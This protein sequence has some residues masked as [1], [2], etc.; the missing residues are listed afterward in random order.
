MVAA[1]INF[2]QGTK[3]NLKPME[4]KEKHEHKG[5]N[6]PPNSSK[7][8][9]SNNKAKEKG[10][11]KGKNRL[12]PEELESYRK[13]NRCFKCGEQGHTYRACPQ[14]NASN[15]QPRASIIEAPK[16]DVHC[17]GSPLSYAWGKVREHDAFILF[18]PGSTH[19]FISHELATKL[20]IQEFE[21]GDAMKA[22]GA[23]IGQDAS[24]TP[25]IGKLRLH[26]QGYVD[27][28]DFFIYPLK[29]EDVIL[30]APWFDRLAASIKFPEGR[31]SFKFREKNMF[32]DAQESG[33]AL[34]DVPSQTA[35]AI[36]EKGSPCPSYATNSC[37]LPLPRR[38]SHPR[39]PL[40][41]PLLWETTW[42]DGYRED[43]S[44]SQDRQ[45]IP[46]VHEV[47]EGS[48]QAKE[49]FPHAACPCE[50]V[51]ENVK[52]VVTRL[53]VDAK[54]DGKDPNAYVDA[55]VDDL[56]GNASLSQGG[57]SGS[58]STHASGNAH[59]S[60]IGT[61]A[62]K[63]NVGSSSKKRKGAQGPLASAFSLQAR[64]QADQALRRF[65]YAEDIPEWK[66]RS[67]F[68]LEMVKAI[69]QVV[70]S[71]VPPTYNALCT[72]ELNDEEVICGKMKV[73][74]TSKDARNKQ[75]SA[76]DLKN[77]DFFFSKIYNVD[78]QHL[79]PVQK[80]VEKLGCEAVYNKEEWVTESSKSKDEQFKQSKSLQI[81]KHETFPKQEA[82]CTLDS[83]PLQ[84]DVGRDIERKV[85]QGSA[86][87]RQQ[88]HDTEEI[89]EKKAKTSASAILRLGEVLSRE[90]DKAEKATRF[91]EIKVRKNLKV[92]G[93]ELQSKTDLPACTPPLSEVKLQSSLQFANVDKVDEQAVQSK[94][95]FPPFD[96][97]QTKAK[98][99]NA[100]NSLPLKT[101]AASEIRSLESDDTLKRAVTNSETSRQ[102]AEIGGLS[103]GDPSSKESLSTSSAVND[104][105]GQAMTGS[106]NSRQLRE[107]DS[108]LK[109]DRSA[110]NLASLDSSKKD[111]I[112]SEI[113]NDP[114]K[115]ADHFSGSVDTE[116]NLVK[117]TISNLK[118]NIEAEEISKLIASII[119][120]SLEG[121]KDQEKVNSHPL[122][123][124]EK[125][126]KDFDSKDENHNVNT[127]FKTGTGSD[128]EMKAVTTIELVKEKR[129]IFKE[130][131]WEENLQQGLT[132]GKVLLLQNLDPSLTSADVC[133]LV[134]SW[135]EEL[136]HMGYSDRIPAV[137]PSIQGLLLIITSLEWM[138]QQQEMLKHIFQGVSAVRVI[139]Q[140]TVCPYGQ[141]LA[142]FDSR[143]LADNALQEM[144]RKCLVLASNKRPIFATKFK[145][146]CNLTKFPGHLALEKLKLSRN[147][148]ADDYKR[149]VSTSHSSQPNTIEYEM[150]IEWRRLQEITQTCQVELFE[151]QQKEIEEIRKNCVTKDF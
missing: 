134:T 2:Q 145:E 83:K 18:D 61:S 26:I 33:A 12:T 75:P 71:Y 49:G 11:Y 109:V 150:A 128:K 117:K 9:Y 51:P 131:P 135:H 149:A 76:I 27:K 93:Q 8:N 38:A 36:A 67:P 105:L 21:M 44:S 130:L 10:V 7:G 74:C 146:T 13:D 139:P 64:K 15:E 62:S 120:P 107:T 84:K 113:H 20:G 40:Q 24:I 68:F 42:M 31:I 114:P 81:S 79:S 6:Q 23:F 34:G 32:I 5:K 97:L 100:E 45:S 101:I 65:F 14:R 132:F 91:D 106:R 115:L 92:D 141:A 121:K 46:T 137:A 72:T 89:A 82:E 58:M 48:S 110:I 103:K 87:K 123:V 1:K 50:S 88:A 122:P 112:I 53:H 144:E 90:S 73:L 80:V 66:V 151:K 22:D 57:A 77:A 78:L 133:D 35:P 25:L 69:G 119:K 98:P 52:E 143:L 118:A 140:E 41:T 142:I 85:S 102:P 127:T 47:G 70:P 108:L 94:S 86:L 56:G 30:G 63:S 16:E 147:L 136:M 60:A 19:N 99:L 43:G 96:A 37:R 138:V 126:M 28:E 29:H 124:S 55:L 95:N 129:R 125:I 104:G 148:G 111:E 116:K 17:K 4:I 59:V 54:S 3:R 39:P